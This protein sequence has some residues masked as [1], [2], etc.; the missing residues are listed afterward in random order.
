MERIS[1]VLVFAI[2]FFCFSNIAIA[3]ESEISNKSKEAASKKEIVDNS[4]TV[5]FDINTEKL[6]PA[7][8]GNDIAKLY[9]DFV[10][11]A[12]LE[13]EEFETTA[14]YEKKIVSVLPDAIYAFK[15]DTDYSDYAKIHPYDADANKFKIELSTHA[16]SLYTFEDQRASIIIVHKL[17]KSSD[18]YI[19]SNAFGATRL[20][21]SYEGLQYG[22]ALVNQNNFGNQSSYIG[23]YRTTNTE[24]DIPLDKAKQ[25]KGNIGIL[26]LCK[27]SLHRSNAKMKY[28]GNDFIFEKKYSVGATINSPTSL[29]YEQKFLNVEVLAIWIYDF[30]TGEIILKKQLKEMIPKV[31]KE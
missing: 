16:L 17:H 26:L 20:V 5:P 11:R 18:S 21:E 1:I 9:S 6:P 31:R 27:S 2:F 15:L 13:R 8:K 3:E 28:R 29:S 12:P 10:K 19:G 24:I 23:G 14:E 7:Y 4:S 25:L 30:R 22:I